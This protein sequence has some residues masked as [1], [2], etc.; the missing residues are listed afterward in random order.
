MYN[1]CLA[2]VVGNALPPKD[3]IDNK[4]E[5]L[6]YVLEKDKEINCEKIWLINRIIDNNYKNKIKCIIGKNKKII[7]IP[8]DI[9]KY[10]NLSDT[11]SKIHYLTNINPARNKLIKKCQEHFKYTIY[12][13]QDCFLLTKNWERIKKFIQKNNQF[14]YYGLISKRLIDKSI[15]YEE[16]NNE[17]MLIFRNDGDIFFKENI[18]F[19]NKDKI[20]LLERLGYNNKNWQCYGNLCKTAGYVMH[21]GHK[22]IIEKNCHYRS[23][24]RYIGLNNLI[25]E[26]DKLC[27]IKII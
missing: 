21:I 19:G 10:K 9:K 14:K 17:P 8:F 22:E 25:K 13:D 18:C 7:E 24:L 23:N 1:Y 15:I 12:L 5:S 3:T 16:P 26:A 2:R 11:Q 20:E 27:Q 4:L 6:K